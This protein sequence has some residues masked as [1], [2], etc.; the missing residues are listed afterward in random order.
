MPDSTS[1][2]A[3]GQQPVQRRGGR[4]HLD[5]RPATVD[6][7]GEFRARGEGHRPRHQVALQHQPVI[8]DSRL[9][10][11]LAADSAVDRRR[12]HC[13]LNSLREPG[14]FPCLISRRRGVRLCLMA[15]RTFL[16]GT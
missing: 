7:P 11:F 8:S 10:I 14:R 5:L 2:K 16:A 6:R 15:R 1:D 12:L 3:A 9:R 13:R 4:D